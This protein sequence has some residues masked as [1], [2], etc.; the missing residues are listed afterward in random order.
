[1]TD[2]LQVL[3]L[4][5]LPVHYIPVILAAF[6]CSGI[7]KGFLGIGLPA[8]AMALLT[9]FID[10]KTAISLMVLPII[11]ANIMQFFR[12]EER[13]QTA[14]KYKYF[15][16]TIMFSIFVTSLF[17]AS[18]PTALLTVAIGVAMVVFSL[19]LLFGMTLAISSH[20]GWQVG[21]GLISGILGGLSSIWSPPVAMYLLA[22]NVSKEEFIGASGFLFLAGCFPLAA[23]LILSGV[24]TFEAALQSV[25]GL[26]AV[27]IGFRI[28][29]L[30]RSYISQDLFRKIVLSVFLILGVRLIMTGLI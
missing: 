7:I 25:L 3:L 28:G 1:M 10:P 29:E 21:V 18:Y 13:R 24:L 9:I 17:I 15:A 22:R 12:S 16:L 8:A 19:N 2:V 23:G 30:M 14:Q 5:N 26:I 27:V 20:L 11:F 4:P 6:L